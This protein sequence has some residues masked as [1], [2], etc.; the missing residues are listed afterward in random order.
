MSI[1]NVGVVERGSNAIQAIQLSQFLEIVISVRRALLERIA[2]GNIAPASLEPIGG[3]TQR[4]A[5]CQRFHFERQSSQRSGN[6]TVVWWSGAIHA[7][8]HGKKAYFKLFALSVI[9]AVQAPCGSFVITGSEPPAS[10]V[11]TVRW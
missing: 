6:A 1:P 8:D 2:P 7:P 5:N 10:N 11:F 4:G 3:P 9:A